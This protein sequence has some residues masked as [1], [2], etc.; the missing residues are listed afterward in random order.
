MTSAKAL[1]ELIPTRWQRQS[2]AMIMAH[3]QGCITERKCFKLSVLL[4][5]RVVKNGWIWSIDS[6]CCS[7]L[8]PVGCRWTGAN[9]DCHGCHCSI[10]GIPWTGYHGATQTQTG[11]QRLWEEAGAARKT[12]LAQ[13]DDANSIWIRTNSFSF[14]YRKNVCNISVILGLGIKNQYLSD[15]ASNSILYLFL[16]LI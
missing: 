4:Y 1:C 14:I 6:F 3:L 12:M 9:P 15:I 7:P 13:G 10:P 5:Q 8:H 2:A 11:V 16:K